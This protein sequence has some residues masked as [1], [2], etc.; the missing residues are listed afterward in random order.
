[1]KKMEAMGLYLSLSILFI[2]ELFLYRVCAHFWA[3]PQ[4]VVDT[5]LLY[6]LLQYRLNYFPFF[7]L[8]VFM[9]GGVIARH[10]EAFLTF[11]RKWKKVLGAAFVLSA[12]CNT[13][14]FYRWILI[15]HMPLE[16]TTNALQQLST[17]GL[18]YTV[19]FILF[20]SAVLDRY[21]EGKLP[22]LEKISDRSFYIYLIHPF[23]L[24]QLSYWIDRAIV[25]FDRFPMPVFYVLLVTV[26]YVA[27]GLLQRIVPPLKRNLLARLPNKA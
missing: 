26:S 18:T 8:F 3:Y 11:I 25:P 6:D 7:Y 22:L 9:M 10:Y 13:L 4:W 23:F 19:I 27:A 12:S 5:P 21:P 20:A 2:L 24:D 15:H 1:M 17:P 16:D 14:I